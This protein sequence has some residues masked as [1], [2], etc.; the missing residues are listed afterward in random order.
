MP[1]LYAV[2]RCDRLQ[3]WQDVA[4]FQRWAEAVRASELAARE[5]PGLVTRVIRK[6]HGFEPAQ[7]SKVVTVSPQPTPI[8]EL[9]SRDVYLVEGASWEEVV[10]DEEWA[11]EKLRRKMLKKQSREIS[12]RARIPTWY[13][14]LNG[15]HC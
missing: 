12:Q 15:D 9:G 7:V 1:R 8:Y 5:S 11:N 4:Y 6:P 13:D 10:P 14:R 3:G 2:Q